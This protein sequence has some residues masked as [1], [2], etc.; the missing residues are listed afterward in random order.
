M[1]VILQ[2]NSPGAICLPSSYIKEVEVSF[3]FFKFTRHNKKTSVLFYFT[4]D[5]QAF[6]VYSSLSNL[7]TLTLLTD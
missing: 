2:G 4:F 7:S 6:S 1:A 3:D 5:H